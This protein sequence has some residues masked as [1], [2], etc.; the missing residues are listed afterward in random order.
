VNREGW[1]RKAIYQLTGVT[2]YAEQKISAARQ[3]ADV[4]QATGLANSQVLGAVPKSVPE[5][6]SACNSL[7]DAISQL[8]VTFSQLSERLTPVKRDANVVAGCEKAPYPPCFTPL[9]GRIVDFAI[10]VQ[11]LNDR[12]RENIGP[13]E[14]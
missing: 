11:S 1:L 6:E 2:M 7:E 12:V 14:I 4:H 8:N 5:I 3:Y 10:R 13:L 9:H